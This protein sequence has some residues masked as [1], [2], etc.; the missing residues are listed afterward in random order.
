[1][2][3]KVSVSVLS[4][5]YNMLHRCKL[6]SS[7]SFWPF[8]RGKYSG[9]GVFGTGMHFGLTSPC[10]YYSA[11]LRNLLQRSSPVFVLDL[12]ESHISHCYV[13]IGP[14]P[15]LYTP[16]NDGASQSFEHINCSSGFFASISTVTTERD[17]SPLFFPSRLVP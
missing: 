16:S 2:S 1:M 10:L 7:T 5:H 15:R 17:V 13:P 8:Y 14:I 3:R 11:D 12:C 9:N 6:S 4:V